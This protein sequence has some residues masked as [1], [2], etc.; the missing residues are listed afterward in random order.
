MTSILAHSEERTIWQQS[1]TSWVAASIAFK[2]VLGDSSCGRICRLE[3]MKFISWEAYSPKENQLDGLHTI[4][5]LKLDKIWAY[6]DPGNIL[7][8]YLVNVILLCNERLVRSQSHDET[9]R[10]HFRIWSTASKIEIGSGAVWVVV[11]CA[12]WTSLL[13]YPSTL[14]NSWS[15]LRVAT[16]LEGQLSEYR[17]P[18][19]MFY[20]L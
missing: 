10:R 6:T 19:N 2:E 11:H 9:Y 13:I 18:C 7:Y 16:G 17:F 20:K 5:M 3:V 14:N 15:K 8:W 1:R 4:H 12:Q